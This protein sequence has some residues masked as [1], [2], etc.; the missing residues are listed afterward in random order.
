MK[1]IRQRQARSGPDELKNN[2][3]SMDTPVVETL[4]ERT[5]YSADV[6]AVLPD[7]ATNELFDDNAVIAGLPDHSHSPAELVFI[8]QR[9]AD[10]DLIIDDLRDQQANGR[11]VEVY[12]VAN[13][14][15]GLTFIASVLEKGPASAVHIISHGSTSGFHL[16]SNWVDSEFAQ[17]RQS[18]L[19]QWRNNLTED[20]DLLLY[21]C[22][23]GESLK[24]QALAQYL[25]TQ[26]GA[27]VATSNNN[28]GHSSFGADWELELNTGAIES[29]SIATES[30]ALAWEHEL[31]TGSNGIDLLE[32]ENALASNPTDYDL[33]GNGGNDLLIANYDAMSVLVNP[34]ASWV[35]GPK[36]NAGDFM[37]DIDTSPYLFDFSQQDLSTGNSGIK[38]NSGSI[39]F[40]M[41]GDQGLSVPGGGRAIVLSDG[42]ISADIPNTVAGNEYILSIYMGGRTAGTHEISL[43]DGSTTE[44]FTVTMP[45]GNS[46]A[47]MDWQPVSIP[48]TPGATNADPTTFTVSAV[49]G[50]PLISTARVINPRIDIGDFTQEDGAGND[51][52]FGGGGRDNI[53]SGAGADYIHGGNDNDTI[54][55]GPGNDTIYGGAGRDVITDGPGNDTVYGGRG[56]DSI[57]D[58]EGDDR[59]LGGDGNDIITDGPGNDTI[60]GGNDDDSIYIHHSSPTDYN[61]FY[62]GPGND[63]FY[64]G[65]HVHANFRIFD[66]AGSDK[67]ILDYDSSRGDST[68]FFPD[69]FSLEGVIGTLEGTGATS[70]TVGDSNYSNPVAWDLEHLNN[71]DSNI[72]IQGGMAD[73][74]IAIG[75][76]STDY[77]GGDGTDIVRV[78]GNAADYSLDRSGFS[79]PDTGD[80]SRYLK[81]IDGGDADIIWDTFEYIDFN[82][83]RYDVSADTFEPR[84]GTI[85]NIGT[86]TAITVK[87]GVDTFI[88]I[89]DINLRDSE[90]DYIPDNTNS[91]ILNAGTQSGSLSV[92]LSTTT[93]TVNP[94]DEQQ[95]N[96]SLD[97]LNERLDRTNYWSYESD[98]SSTQISDVLTITITDSN[99]AADE[100]RVS[101]VAQIPITIIHDPVLSNIETTSLIFNEND[102]ATPI[103]NALTLSDPNLTPI[104]SATI[105]LNNYV[106]G[107]AV[108]TLPPTPNISASFDALT[109]TLT[110][111]GDDTVANYESALRSVTYANTSENPD[112]TSRS[113]D[114]LVNDGQDNSN[115]VSR[116]ISVVNIND[117]P[118]LSNFTQPVTDEDTEIELSIA[119]LLALGDENDIDGTVKSF[120]VVSSNTGSL[121]IGANAA[122]AAPYAVSSNDTIDSSNNIYWTPPA[123]FNT[124][125]NSAQS[126]FSMLARDDDNQ[127]SST[128]VPLTVYVNDINDAPSLTGFS[129]DID[130]TDEDTEVELTFSELT[131][132]GNELDIDGNIDHFVVQGV[133]TG[134]LRIGPNQASAT[135]FAAL[136][137][138]TI[139]LNNKAYWTPANNKNTTTD[140]PQ[141]AFSVN[142]VDDDGASSSPAVTATVT[143]NDINDNPTL[144]V[145]TSEV[146][147]TDEDTEVE[148]LFTE[149]TANS[150]EFDADGTVDAMIVQAVSSGSLRIGTSSTAATVFEAGTNDTIDSTRNAYWTPDPNA[151]TTADGNQEAF[152]VIARDNDNGLSAVTVAASVI[153]NDINDLPVLTSFDAAVATTNE[154]TEVEIDFATLQVHGDD[155]DIDGAI[156]AFVVQAVNS[157]NLKIGPNASTATDYVA[158]TNDTI[159]TVNKAYWT[160]DPESNTAANGNQFAFTVA[161]RDDD[162][163]LSTTSV[164]ATVYVNDVNDKPVFSSFDTDVSIT[165]EDTEVA[166][167]LNDLKL[168]GNETDIDGNVD[169][170]VVQ[171]VITGSLKLGTTAAS[172]TA[173]STGSNDTVDAVNNAYWSPEP[174]NNN[175]VDGNQQAFSVVVRDDDGA[176]SDTPVVTTVYVN[177]IND[178][179]GLTTFSNPLAT[180]DEDTSIEIVFNDFITQGDSSD[181]DGSV[182][183]FIIQSVVTGSLRIGPSAAGAT[184]FIAGSNDTVDASNHAYWTPAANQNTTEDGPQQ[185][186]TAVARDDDGAV[187][188][189]AVT[190]ILQVNDINDEPA[191]SLFTSAVANTDEDTEVAITLNGLLTSGNETDIDGV[192][193][194]FVVT[195]VNSGTLT[196]GATSATATPFSVAGNDTIDASNNAYWTADPEKNTP[197]DNTQFAFSLLARD[198]DGALSAIPLTAEV[199]VNDVNDPPVLSSFSN[200]VDTTDE[201]TSVAISFSELTSQADESDIDGFVNAFV[202]QDVVT[203]A[204]RIGTSESSA[205]PWATGSNDIIDS[206]NIAYWTPDAEANTPVDGPQQAFTVLARDEDGDVSTSAVTTIVQVNDVNDPPILTGFVPYIDIT[207]EDTE[208]EIRLWELIADSDAADIDGSVVGMLVT[209]VESGTLSI[210]ATAATATPFSAT[211]NLI[212]TANTGYWTPDPNANGILP[213]ISV[214]AIDDDGEFSAV[215]VTTS[216]L[217][218]DVN[219]RPTLSDFSTH[220]S[221]T[222]EDTEIEITVTD[223]LA[224]GDQAD[225]DGSVGAFVVQNIASGT[226]RIGSNSSTATTWTSGTNDVIDVSNNAYW[227]PDPEVNT[228]VNGDQPAFSVVAKDDD[229]GLSSVPV[230]ATVYVNDVND[231]PTLLPFVAPVGATDEDTELSVTFDD[232]RIS[233][234]ASDYDGTV[235]AFVVQNVSS[236]KLNIGSSATT[237]TPYI[238]GSNDIIDNTRNAYWTPATEL[239]TPSD[240]DQTA[241]TVAAIDDDGGQSQ[242]QT[243]LV[244]VNDINDA[245]TL[246]A[247]STHVDTTD[248]DTEI[249]IS[250]NALFSKGDQ[251]DIDGSVTAFAVQSV[252][253]GTLRIGS[254]VTVASPWI[255]GVN[256]TID[257]TD[258]AYWT[259]DDNANTPVNGNQYAFSVVAVDEDGG[260]SATAV[261]TQVLVNDIN[262]EPIL[263]AYTN[264]VATTDEDTPVEITFGGLQAPGTASDQDGTVQAFVVQS[265]DSGILSIGA[266][267]AVA[268]DFLAGVNDTI[269][270]ANHAYWT[271]APEQNTPVDGDQQAFTLTAQDDDDA[272]SAAHPALVYVNDI[273]DAPTLASFDTPV[274]TTDEDTEVEISFTDIQT[275]NKHHDKDGSV[276]EFIV[277]N[278]TSGQLKIGTDAASATLFVAGTNNTIDTANSAYWTPAPDQNT[279]ANGDQQ[280]ISVIAVDDDGSVSAAQIV[281]V[282]VNDVNDAPI[283]TPFDSPVTATD[284]DTE[285]ELSLDDLQ[286]HGKDSD[287]DGSVESFVVQSV[288]SGSLKIGSDATTATAFLIGSNDTIDAS[289]NAYWTPHPDRNT[290]VDGDQQ[291]LIVAA[292]DDDGAL[293][294]A[295][296]TLIH[297]NDVNDAPVLTAFDTPV[298]TTDEDTEV[299]LSF[300]DLQAYVKDSDPDGSVESF[301]VQNVLSGT[302]RIGSDA[303]TAS[304]FLAGSNDTINATA[305]AYWTPDP[306]RNTPV[307]GD[308]QALIITA[309]D[310]DGAQSAVQTTLIYVNDINDAPVLATFDAPVTSTDEDTEVELSLDDLQAHSKDSDADGSV[311]SFVVQSVLSG[312]LKIGSDAATATTFISGSND[313]IDATV[314][315]YWTPDPDRNTPVDG[316]R[317]A[318]II[319]AR[320]NDGAQSAAQT[321][322]IYVNDINDAPVLAAIDTPVTTTDEDTE[323]VLSFDDL[324]AHGKD[325]DADGSVESFVVQSVLSGTLK[326][327]GDAGTAT[328][329]LTGS[330]DTIDAASNAYWTPNQDRNTPLDGDQPALILN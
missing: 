77:R 231:N 159:D 325:S 8:D 67:L 260:I 21:G 50:D 169:A 100:G 74:R 209:S 192:V 218:N 12:T 126:A 243:A 75:F 238:V 227:T 175:P 9:V 229:D 309:R 308:Q 152:S 311:E 51:S 223:M 79:G 44:N 120:I 113:V 7:P 92:N 125:T 26:T 197:T 235:Q 153:V 78:Y 45:D 163:A 173:Y 123:N 233:G 37:Y 280:A 213:A 156:Q 267:A 214:V 140:G 42:E 274:E 179:P 143:V 215:P 211:N 46:L 6:L 90:L 85:T 258:N 33:I 237:A 224:Q 217:V 204:L 127:T 52:V 220:V 247:F 319:T 87:D 10:I 61:E 196:I 165:D 107:E 241:F 228:P 31:L 275:Q 115:T 307:D 30:L 86:T 97:A 317:Q 310:N 265:V 283:L 261:R 81:I 182:E 162:G 250:F 184:A 73:D 300:D 104:Q 188:D 151:N 248:E 150:D 245:P 303:A 290:P 181:S 117:L 269:D 16:G 295:R 53:V 205:A 13:E 94:P 219:D 47:T 157:G 254:G 314:N 147:T 109:G 222:D 95:F 105:Q 5:L 149:L 208:E 129:A 249:A 287:A 128:A 302:L 136:S 298:T 221:T 71:V 82:D 206:S 187:S 321:T 190:A 112:I 19:Q 306:N 20:A 139:D 32:G 330:N 246:T 288:L 203:G 25:A 28:T 146:S 138:D 133:D 89:S 183:G 148:I 304:A 278:V 132:Q 49:S 121:R 322:L 294:A 122:A 226:L 62:G 201:D 174:E 316:D 1:F 292:R 326:I 210:G 135:P 323:V 189:S 299:V 273:N 2:K 40:I 320:D 281:P 144:S 131:N 60:T 297:V 167:T 56:N 301:V 176:T 166:I 18:V 98:S 11:H 93:V 253:S 264:P 177:D 102:P 72:S 232:L 38:V 68:Y 170:F 36:V 286:A 64:L 101:T 76:S 324:Q 168:H 312:S 15:D 23:L 84:P 24:G 106:A 202:V 3:R 99:K 216:M 58:G 315:A 270:A 180:T 230:A 279:P 96:G 154:D 277:K 240:G 27:D 63:T 242:A 251:N 186:F 65:N 39:D 29:G 225:I 141:T 34:P 194:A 328:P 91:Y 119:D 41:D 54:T 114:I 236:G 327:G 272:Q 199:T 271:P 259:P 191:L 262:D 329:F 111:V 268:S 110:L 116:N 296:T 193:N 305:N 185:A 35:V 124:P 164:T 43:S 200:D 4:E 252:E 161:V 276:Q 145:F 134:S 318:M 130:T 137:N 234:S 108:L 22:N 239:N 244:Y 195:T 83:A 142:V 284:E 255:A 289:A 171:N 198:E 158:N 69:N 57:T 160:P 178:K 88:D 291:A 282:Y 207:D 103:S 155:L 172:A 293:S 70:Y 257:A 59:H 66:V 48:F 80:D 118:T 313:T 212:N 14:A 266:N 285:V 17:D 55:D 263:T 256:D